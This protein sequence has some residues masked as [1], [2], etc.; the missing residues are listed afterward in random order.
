MRANDDALVEAS[1]DAIRRQWATQ[2]K[3]IVPVPSLR[4][5]ALVR[6]FAARLAS[7]LNMPLVD[8]LT[9]VRQH[10]PQAEMHN[11]FQQAANLL[12]CFSVSAP[13]RGASIL[14]VDD[15][16]DSKW[17][18]TVLGDLLQRQGAAAVYPYVLAATNISE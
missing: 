11:S 9:H 3:L 5:P 18:L 7:A 16:A 15:V 13:V 12:D 14:L 17:T 4:R 10:P 1:A 8:A 6:D 2:P